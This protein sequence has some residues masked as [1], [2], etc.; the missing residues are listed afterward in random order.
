MVFSRTWLPEVRE[1]IGLK[2]AEQRAWWTPRTAWLL[3]LVL[4]G[5]LSACTVQLVAPYNSELAQTA[6]GM[7]AEVI[8]WDLHMRSGAGTISDDSRHPDV[9]G[10]LNKWQGAAG[11]MLT[12][13]IS[14]DPG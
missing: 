2:A 4:G 10:T 7:Q 12:L 11:A 8:A 3:I 9:L 5:V 6:S 13:A 1:A 14:N